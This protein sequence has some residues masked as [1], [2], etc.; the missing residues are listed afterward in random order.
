MAEGQHGWGV[1]WYQPLWFREIAALQCYR[2]IE[3][4]MIE[5]LRI[6]AAPCSVIEG[7]GRGWYVVNGGICTGAQG[8]SP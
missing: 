3:A 6:L 2:V 1:L 8:L 7:R 4:E 5:R